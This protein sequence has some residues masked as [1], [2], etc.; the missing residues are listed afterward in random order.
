MDGSVKRLTLK[1]PRDEK[2]VS[3]L[4]A[5]CAASPGN[6]WEKGSGETKQIKYEAS[7]TKI[8]AKSSKTWNFDIP[9]CEKS[10][11]LWI[12]Y[13]KASQKLPFEVSAA[14]CFTESKCPPMGGVPRNPKRVANLFLVYAIKQN[15]QRLAYTSLPNSMEWG[16]K[17]RTISRK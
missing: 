8:P 6:T 4:E 5:L 16:S 12:D 10:S 13:D 2:V 14:K 15:T 1:N 7:G 17:R 9:G 11:K 3:D